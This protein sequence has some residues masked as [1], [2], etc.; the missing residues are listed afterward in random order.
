MTDLIHFLDTMNWQMIIAIFAVF[1]YFTRDIR[2][3]VKDIKLEM[4]EQGKRI[5]HLYQIC[6]DL[7][8]QGKQ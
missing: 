1:W 8:K 6:V 7:L 2:S 5:D 3:D 4:K